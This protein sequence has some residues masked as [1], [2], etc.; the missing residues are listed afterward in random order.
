M[1]VCYKLRLEAIIVDL[2]ILERRPLGGGYRGSPNHPKICVL[3]SLALL[4]FLHLMCYLLLFIHY[5]IVAYTV[6]I[7]IL[8]DSARVSPFT[9]CSPTQFDS[10]SITF[11]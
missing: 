2:E 3:I 8:S 4:L 1:V 6:V 5:L 7:Y 10:A 11:A 9:Y